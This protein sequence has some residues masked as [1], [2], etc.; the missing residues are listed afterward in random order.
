MRDPC[1]EKTSS[2]SE[3]LRDQREP[4][5]R[6]DQLLVDEFLD[7]EIGKLLAIAGSLDSSERKVRR[8]DGRVVDEDHACFDS[9]GQPLAV[10]DVLGVNGPAEAERSCYKAWDPANNAGVVDH[11]TA[12]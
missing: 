5:G 10:L 4:I 12:Y 3:L 8:A 7:S 9:A 1:P 11:E 2:T 6:A